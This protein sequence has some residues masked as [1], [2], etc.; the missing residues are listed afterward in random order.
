MGFPDSSADKE[1]ACNSGDPGSI[2]GLGRSTEEGMGYPKSSCNEGH[3]GLIPGLGR[4]PWRRKGLLTPVFLPGESHGQRRSLA[5]YCP[6]CHQS[7]IG[8]SNVHK[9]KS[10]GECIHQLQI[11][12]WSPSSSFSGNMFVTGV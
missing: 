8:L 1:F 7:Q 2:P 12:S 5:V 10:A 3:L 11:C 4:F 9:I 6:W